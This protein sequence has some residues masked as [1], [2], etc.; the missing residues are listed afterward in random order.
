MNIKMENSFDKVLCKSWQS[1]STMKNFITEADRLENASWRLWFMEKMGKVNGKSKNAEIEKKYCVY[2]QVQVGVMSCD[3]CCHDVY[4]VKCFQ[5]VHK[6]GHLASHI[7]HFR[8]VE[9]NSVKAKHWEVEMDTV[10]QNMMSN[11]IPREG[12]V[13]VH[14]INT[15][16]RVE[17]NVVCA[18]CQGGHMTYE[19]PELEN[20]QFDVTL[21][22]TFTTIHND[23]RS[24]STH[25]YLG[26]EISVH[27][28][29][30]HAFAPNVYSGN[31]AF[32]GKSFLGDEGSQR[33]GKRGGVFSAEMFTEN[34]TPIHVK[35]DENGI[36]TGITCIQEEQ[37]C[38]ICGKIPKQLPCFCL[39]EVDEMDTMAVLPP[40]VKVI[41]GMPRQPDQWILASLAGEADGTVIQNSYEADN[42]QGVVQ[43]KNVSSIWRYRYVVLYRNILY[44]YLSEKHYRQSESPIGHCN[45]SGS[46]I[47][48][49]NGHYI[50]ECT[51]YITSTLVNGTTKKFI[52]LSQETELKQWYE[53]LCNAAALRIDMLF[54]LSPPN[55]GNSLELGKGRFSVVRKAMRKSNNRVNDYEMNLNVLIH[56]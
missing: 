30:K 8:T 15:S 5:L 41:P 56:V 9:S 7:G 28:G 46:R 19:C 34:H 31:I 17:K 10:I 14:T 13:S 42:V 50:L 23:N 45:L 2:C 24:N 48:D 44:E 27:G 20:E 4:C 49:V 51:Y 29:V 55:G 35:N 6:R 33:R 53:A 16:S 11:R 54:D 12:D 40:V 22:K 1:F 52:R 47:R 25:A 43:L 26:D 38:K 21:R 18:H 39:G 3:G 32:D 37:N 36:F